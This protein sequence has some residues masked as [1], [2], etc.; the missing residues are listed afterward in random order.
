MRRQRKQREQEHPWGT[1]GHMVDSR[2]NVAKD[3]ERSF[4]G[5]TLHLFVVGVLRPLVRVCVVLLR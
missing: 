4:I 2:F 1:D 5:S 3:T